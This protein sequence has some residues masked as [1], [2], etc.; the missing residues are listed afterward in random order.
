MGSLVGQS[1]ER[2][3]QALRSIDALAPCVCVIDESRRR[4]PNRWRAGQR[5]HPPAC[6]GTFLSWLNDHDSDVFRRLHCQRHLR[7]PPEFTRAERFDGTFFLD[8]PGPDQKAAIWRQYVGN[9]NSTP[10]NRS[11][12]TTAGP[13]P[14]SA[15]AAGSALLDLPPVEAA[16]HISRWP[17]P[18][19]SRRTAPH[20][21][22]VAVSPPRR[23]ACSS[24]TPHRNHGE[25]PGVGP[26][27]PARATARISEPTLPLVARRVTRPHTKGGPHNMTPRADDRDSWR[28]LAEVYFVRSGHRPRGDRLG[29]SR[30]TTPRHHHHHR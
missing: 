4:S 17:P 5:S 20:L 27:T 10:T 15:P 24:T 7:L 25:L 2:T 1:E 14:R 28:M 13:V 29:T 30:P 18:P 23:A 3:R 8:L 21:A 22:T 12:P 6:S 19:P 26:R 16:R 11:P 9:S